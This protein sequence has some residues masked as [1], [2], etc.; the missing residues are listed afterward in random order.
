MKMK[1]IVVLAGILVSM[2]ASSSRADDAA[3]APLKTKLI[4]VSLF[5][6]GLGFMARE[7]ELPKGDVK[8]LVESLPAPVHGTFWVYSRDDAATVEDLVALVCRASGVSRSS[9]T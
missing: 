1:R 2:G 5:K 7:G 4:A 3:A 9:S 8:L 6:N